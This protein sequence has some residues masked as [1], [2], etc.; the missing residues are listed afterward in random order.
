MSNPNPRTDHLPKLGDGSRTTEKEFEI[1]S[2][3]GKQC[4]SNKRAARTASELFS[5][6]L[7]SEISNKQLEKL[8][9]SFGM[10]GKTVDV[11]L[12]ASVLNNA[13]RKGTINDAIQ[14]FD[15]AGRIGNDT[16][17]EAHADLMRALTGND[18]DT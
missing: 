6:A 3:G 14:A 5:V 18:V 9:K 7:S 12:V 17:E 16:D 15:A 10:E 2:K 4:A 8:I 11:A 13:M 1:R